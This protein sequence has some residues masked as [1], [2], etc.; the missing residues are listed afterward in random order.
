MIYT[1]S[2]LEAFRIVKADL[3]FIDEQWNDSID[4]DSLRRFSSVLRNLLVDEGGLMQKVISLLNLDYFVYAS[5][6]PLLK[7]NLNDY[8]FFASGGATYH[9][10]TLSDVS[11]FKRILTPFE[12]KKGLDSKSPLSS[13]FKLSQFLNAICII[14]ESEIFTRIDLIKFV[15]NKLGGAHYEL[16]EKKLARMRHLVTAKN[17]YTIG[18]KNSIY[19]EFLS[20]GQ[21][22][23]NS[24]YTRKIKNKIA[25]ILEKD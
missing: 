17:L 5:H 18:G 8:I 11:E 15:S 21:L 25:S 9:G 24:K 7:K 16:D 1:K 19:F 23:S 4:D 14:H 20:I 2:E 22:I 13:K 10:M 12:I 3:D 6:S